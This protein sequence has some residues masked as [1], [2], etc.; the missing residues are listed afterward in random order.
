MLDRID[1]HAS[2]APDRLAIAE[3][4]RLLT[5]GELV[6]Q[7][8]STAAVRHTQCWPYHPICFG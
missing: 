7:V 6:Q 4:D 5:Y 1:A 8:S 3:D 2:A